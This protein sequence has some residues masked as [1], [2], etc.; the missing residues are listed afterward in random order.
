M[1][2]FQTIYTV[3]LPQDAY[4]IKSL[5]ESC[6]IE[7]Y[8]KD[9]LTIQSDNLLSPALNGVKIQVREE[10]IVEAMAILE[11]QGYISKEYENAED[12]WLKV[13]RWMAPIPVFN[14]LHPA[15]ALFSLLLIVL[16]L[17]VAPFVIAEM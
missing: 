1:E 11:E 3:N 15:V 8:L 12:F 10:K 14:K 2:S 5:L 7:V 9:E 17:V 4:L 13:E 6:D 16:L